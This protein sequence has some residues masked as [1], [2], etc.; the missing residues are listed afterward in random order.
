MTFFQM[1]NNAFVYLAEGIYR[2]FS[3]HDDAYPATGMQAYSG[4]IYSKQVDLWD[5][6]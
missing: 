2:I 1:L 5:M 4:D 3:P 6:W